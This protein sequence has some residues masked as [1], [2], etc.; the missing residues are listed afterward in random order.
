[1]KAVL[2]LM[3]IFFYIYIY[4]VKLVNYIIKTEHFAKIFVFF[5]FKLILC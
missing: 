2:I 1:M 4:I 5:D 3:P